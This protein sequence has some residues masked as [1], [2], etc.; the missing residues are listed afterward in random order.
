MQIFAQYFDGQTSQS[1]VVILKTENAMLIVEGEN[2]H[3]SFS[4][5]ETEISENIGR[6]PIKI[7]FHDGAYIE[8]ANDPILR[9]M[10][11]QSGINKSLI[12]TLERHWHWAILA[13][14]LLM[15]LLGWGY[16]RGIPAFSAWVVK[17]IPASLMD[18]IDKDALNLLDEYLFRP[19]TL[20]QSQKHILEKK[21]RSLRLTNND[22]ATHYTLIFRSSREGPNAFALSSHHIILTDEMVNLLQ[23]DEAILGVLAHELG[24][25]HYR[26][27]TQRIVQTS[28]TGVLASVLLG[29]VSSLAANLPTIL[30]DLHY[31]RD[32]ERQADQYAINILEKNQIDIL[33]LLKGFEKIDAIQ[34]AEGKIPVY[35]SSHPSTKERIENIQNTKLK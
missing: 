27:L 18:Q 30:L 6:A 7:R 23:S 35:L 26:H 19:S 13:T 28:I 1:H 32:A 8:V 22:T 33:F 16:I 25:L 29:D 17:Y 5:K 11:S 24:H 12:S 2:I 31:S 14:I 9:A 20:S 21:F 10:I 4:I 3:R 34:R 15:A